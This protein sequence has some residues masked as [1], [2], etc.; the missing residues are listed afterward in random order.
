MT[1]LNLTRAE[2][3]ARAALVKVQH[4]DI[5]LDLSEG[6]ST[7]S[8]IT[9]VRFH[10]GAGSTFID[11]RAAKVSEVLLD[12]RDITPTVYSPEAGLPLDLTEGEH[13]LRI[14]AT[15]EYTHTGE[16]MHRFVDPAD[17]EPYLYTQFETAFAKQVFACF[18]QPDMKATYSLQVI[19]PLGWR[20]IGNGPQQVDSSGERLIHTSQVD[21]PL[22]TY[23]VAVCAG[24]YHEVTDTWRGTLTHHPETPADQ[25]HELEV[26]LGIYCRKS[27]AEHL[28][29]ERL[30][31]ETKQGFDWYHE[32]FGMAYPFHKYDQ[33][34]CPEYNWGAMEN[35]GCV[36]IR[37][38]YVF[39]SKVT[40][41][42][43]ERR[44]DTVLHELAHMWFGDL[45]TMEWWDDLWLNESFATWAAALS[46]SEATEYRN[47]WVTF[48]NVQKSWAYQQDQLPSTHPVFADAAD[49][50]TAEQN[51][52]GITYA[53]GASL[54]KQLQAYV[55]R[56][57]FLAGVRSHFA[58]HA[59]NN[60]TFADLLSTLAAASKRD[61][62]GWAN[63][64]LTTTGITTLRPQF[65]VQNG[66]YLTFD[67]AQSGGEPRD[68]RIAI[69]LYSLI[70]GRVQ[71]THRVELDVAGATTP[72]PELKEVPVA[73]LVVVNDDDLTYCTIGLDPESL[74][75][76]TEHIGDISDPMPRTL[77]WSAAWEMTRNAQMRARD[78]LEL[79]IRGAGAETEISVLERLLDQAGIAVT[80][81]A[82][83]EW[84]REVG[85]A[86]LSRFLLAGAR[87][88]EPGSDFQLAFVKALARVQLHEEALDFFR[89]LDLAGLVVDRDL[90]WLALTAL[91]AHG[92]V[93]D[94]TSTIS[95]ELSRDNSST[96]QMF[97]E[98]AQTAVNT[99]AAKLTAFESLTSGTLSN[100]QL[101]HQLEGF[102]WA[103]SS[104]NL[105]QFN[106]RF[107]ELAPS[108]WAGGSSE[109]ALKTLVGLYPS[110]DVSDAGLAR[111]DAFLTSATHPA[112]LVRVISEERSR[113]ERALRNRR[114]DGQKP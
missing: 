69:G 98:R 27:L 15:C 93:K 50:Q 51:F 67:V 105:Q 62:S 1:S 14:T 30:F 35:A 88:A 7:F 66:C 49:V 86:R 24:P 107:F 85:N 65:T 111:A 2:A 87:A 76:I 8:S 17:N 46:Q 72:V 101:R 83:P 82:D 28:D 33:I 21:Y 54:L 79:V 77:C 58:N 112:G 63:Q 113:V 109:I 13:S 94:V 11:L 59:F 23:L 48:A 39:A 92:K 64:W 56:D 55:G 38:E 18:D 37:D 110:W 68:H 52:D 12:G 60:A 81:Y 73:D 25:P 40:G 45:V 3:R 57:A 91:I 89:E 74:R 36:T 104:P 16:G 84:A 90:R 114:Y 43:Y 53:K 6:E 100:L 42:L 102:T 34:F 78:F 32:H 47:A 96:S 44:A 103:G 26:P 9:V 20:V 70:D 106:E 29:A 95:G 71:R 4:Y 99:A 75:F 10:S 108:I 5:S 61:L 19:T 80:S 22:S 41:Y 31:T 97:A